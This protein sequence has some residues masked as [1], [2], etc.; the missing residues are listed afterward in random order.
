M[1]QFTYSNTIIVKP[2]HTDELKHVNNV[3]YVQWIQDIAVKHW[4]AV[5]VDEIRKKYVWVILR[6]EIDY[7][8]PGFAGD[9][10][11][12]KTCVLNV[13]KFTSDRQVQIFRKSDNTLLAQSKTTWC[14]LN[15]AS[16]RP[17]IIP[18]EIKAIFLP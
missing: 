3:A 17:T 7:K 14:M 4:N 2:E 6:H 12:L 10:L 11:L 5:A 9:E 8:K 13:Q 1:E 15:A 18:D 16:F